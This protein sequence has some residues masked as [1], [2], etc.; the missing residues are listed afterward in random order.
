MLAEV[1]VN[2]FGLHE[3]VKQIMLCWDVAHARNGR[4]N[5]PNVNIS[6]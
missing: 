5:N 4:S 2:T 3:A 1:R 6:D